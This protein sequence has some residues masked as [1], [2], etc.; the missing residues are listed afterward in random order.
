MRWYDISLPLYAGMATWPGDPPVTL[1]P[2]T[3]PP[4]GPSAKRLAETICTSGDLREGEGSAVVSR[5]TL[6]THS[7]THVDA[8]RHLLPGGRGVDGLPLAQLIGPARVLHLPHVAAQ[9]GHANGQITAEH[10]RV[11]GVSSSTPRLLLRTANSDRNLLRRRAFS[12]QYVALALDAAE[13]LLACDV[14][15][16]G[17]DA[18]SVDPY[19]AEA[20]PVH[21]L[22]LEHGV[23]ILEGLDLTRVPP[24]EYIL[25]CLPLRLVGADGAPT[26]AVLLDPDNHHAADAASRR[27]S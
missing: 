10:L 7:G 5:L 12:P 15:L 3:P 22:L 6:G 11:A 8:P 17:I 14:R 16:V 25:V 20:G 2:L 27:G 1:E 13:Y 9:D 21:R 24:K 26:R 18:L 4:E 23:I 19:E